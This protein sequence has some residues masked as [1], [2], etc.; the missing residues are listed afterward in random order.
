M[1]VVSAG[2]VR[3]ESGLRGLRAVYAVSVVLLAV[4]A[5]VTLA[6]PLLLPALRRELATL[7]DAGKIQVLA[8]DGEWVLQYNLLNGAEIPAAFTFEVAGSPAESGAAPRVL[9]T[10]SVRVDAGKTYVFI[11]HLLPAQV[12]D[13]TVRFTLQRDGESA[14]LEELTLHLPANGKSR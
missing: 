1:A 9:H 13:G 10:S 11:Y 6:S 14:P 5:L 2:I 3:P 7:P 4:L 8:K 12:P